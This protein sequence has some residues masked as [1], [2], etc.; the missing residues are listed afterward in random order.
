[1]SEGPDKHEIRIMAYTLGMTREQIEK[2]LKANYKGEELKIN[3]AELDK[4]L[5]DGAE[6]ANRRT[7][8]KSRAMN[9]MTFS[10]IVKRKLK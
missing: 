6:R 1:M 10:Q 5:P 2:E 7:I 4:V 9:G 8:R 3:L